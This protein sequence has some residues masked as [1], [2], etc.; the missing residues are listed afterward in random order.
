MMSCTDSRSADGSP[1]IISDEARE[2]GCGTV[3]ISVS[4]ME[5]LLYTDFG[6]VKNGIFLQLRIL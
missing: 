2:Y 1:G 3:Q 6:F 4:D 5:V